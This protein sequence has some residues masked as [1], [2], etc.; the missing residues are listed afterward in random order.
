MV[1]CAE[2]VPPVQL[3]ALCEYT[4]GKDW[5]E[6]SRSWQ[7]VACATVPDTVTTPPLGPSSEGLVLATGGVGRAMADAAQAGT[8]W[9]RPMLA[10][11]TIKSA[12]FGPRHRPGRSTTNG[13]YR[14][15]LV[16][17]CEAANSL[18]WTA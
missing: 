10:V 9:A 2:K 3:L 13:N 7:V 12:T 4:T 8:D 16:I 1:T 6:S 14:R 15:T 17:G 5:A 11:A 18:V